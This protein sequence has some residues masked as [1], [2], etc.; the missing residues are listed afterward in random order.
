MNYSLVDI[1]IAQAVVCQKLIRH[2]LRTCLDMLFH[3]TL[4][5]L[6]RCP[7]ISIRILPPRSSKRIPDAGGLLQSCVCPCACSASW[8]TDEAIGYQRERAAGALSK[9]LEAFIAKKLQPYL[10]T[11]PSDFYNELICTTAQTPALVTIS[12]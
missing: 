4:S 10:P 6:S 9:I 3:N 11:F 12:G 7:T 2:N 8:W 1:I 5:V